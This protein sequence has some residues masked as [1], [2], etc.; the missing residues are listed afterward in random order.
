MVRTKTGKPQ[1]KLSGD[2]KKLLLED[3]RRC[4]Q[5]NRTFNPIT[6]EGSIGR[7]KKVEITDHPL[8]VGK[9]TLI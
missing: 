4:A 8:P 2:V 5:N 3:E 1:A 9:A 7:R 6:G